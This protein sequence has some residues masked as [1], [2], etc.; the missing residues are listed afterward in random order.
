M[1]ARIIALETCI[2]GNT[3]VQDATRASERRINGLLHEA[4]SQKQRADGNYKVL[5]SVSASLTS[6]QVYE[7][8]LVGAFML[9][10]TEFVDAVGD[11]PLTKLPVRGASIM[12]G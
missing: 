1:K 4:E 8:E 7:R 10:N 9:L 12:D 2:R 5:A 3:E 11:D 6:A